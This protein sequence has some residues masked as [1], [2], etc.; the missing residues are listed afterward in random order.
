[1]PLDISGN[2]GEPVD[3]SNDSG[4][5]SADP[6][7]QDVDRPMRHASTVPGSVGHA[8][9]VPANAQKASPSLMDLSA[10]MPLLKKSRTRR[11]C[12][13]MK[14]IAVKTSHTVASV[15]LGEL[16]YAEHILFVVGVKN[17]YATGALWCLW[18]IGA[19]VGLLAVGQAL[20]LNF[21][22]VSTLMLPLPILTILLLSVDLLH[23]LMQSM[24]VWII[25]ILQVA[26]FVD[27][28]YYC[29]ADIRRVFWY[30]YLPTM[31]SSVLVDAYP[32]KYRPV[33]TKLFFVSA[34]VIL[35]VWNCF[36]IFKW[37]AVAVNSLNN[38]AFTLHHVADQFTLL[39][40]YIRHLCCSFYRPSYFV[41]IKADVRHVGH[42]ED[43]A[44]VY[45]HGLVPPTV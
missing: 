30:C 17:K 14:S 28:I 26:L 16:S 36:M 33:F 42:E 10:S 8:A 20:P 23:E 2:S 9:T 32:A 21:V 24:D 12:P 35:V 11:I 41:M 7:E 19:I 34:L 13:D 18:T 29:R 6:N 1:M 15:I 40:F 4:D 27:G 5:E 25:S 38:I 43:H 45:T 22:W 31:I 44:P 39:V 37:E 3:D